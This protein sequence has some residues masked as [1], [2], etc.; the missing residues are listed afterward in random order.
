MQRAGE[1]R[2]QAEGA[3]VLTMFKATVAHVMRG[4]AERSQEPPSCRLDRRAVR[5]AGLVANEWLE[6]RPRGRGGH[7]R[8]DSRAGRGPGPCGRGAGGGEMDKNS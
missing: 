4:G 2:F 1:R 6:G 3:L 5:S 8:L 7:P